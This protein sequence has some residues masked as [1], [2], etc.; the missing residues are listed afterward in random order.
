MY[1]VFLI[2][3]EDLL[4]WLRATVA[5]FASSRDCGGKSTDREQNTFINYI[6]SE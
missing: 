2:M 1:I 6:V 4:E 5:I 3:S